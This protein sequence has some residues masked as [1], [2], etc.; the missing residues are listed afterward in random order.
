[1]Q[2]SF[3]FSKSSCAA[4]VVL[5]LT[6]AAS[7]ASKVHIITFGRWMQVQ[8]FALGDGPPITMKVRS[9]IVDGRAKE[10][11]F[12][13]PHEITERLS[14]VRRAFRVNDSLPEEAAPHWKWERGGWLLLDRLTGRVS[15]TNL[16]AFDPYLSA[17]S[18]YRDYVA[19]CGVEDD[20]KNV[21]AMVVQVSRRKPVLKAAVSSVVK[22]DAEPASVCPAPVWQRNPVRVSFTPAVGEKQTF[23][24]RGSAVDLISDEDED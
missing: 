23:A 8:C 17:A 11:V 22:D 9:L 18:W 1:M 5:S 19:Y 12:G 6:I 13:V 14:V 16:P 2:Q 21:F 3:K 10:Y 4:A 24:I 20:R 7:A 15:P